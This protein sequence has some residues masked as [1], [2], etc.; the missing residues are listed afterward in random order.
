[1][2][3]IVQKAF[4]PQSL[5]FLLLVSQSFDFSKIKTPG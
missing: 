1:V 2:L 5:G 3:L 4:V